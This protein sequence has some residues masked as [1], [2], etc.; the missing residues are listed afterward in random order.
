MQRR[1]KEVLAHTQSWVSHSAPVT[2]SLINHEKKIKT[3]SEPYTPLLRL[4]HSNC[5]ACT[6]THSHTVQVCIH[7]CKNN[8]AN[9]VKGVGGEAA[10]QKDINSLS[11]FNKRGGGGS[12]DKDEE[13]VKKEGEHRRERMKENERAIRV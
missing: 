5:Y 1:K 3:N 6:N 8:K 12:R 11:E 7:T 10:R 2:H 13:E 4:K 9:L